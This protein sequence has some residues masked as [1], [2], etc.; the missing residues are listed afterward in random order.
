MPCRNERKETAVSLKHELRGLCLNLILIQP[1][2]VYNYSA[3]R[4]KCKRSGASSM[5]GS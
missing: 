3:T 2:L 1:P 4:V 5:T